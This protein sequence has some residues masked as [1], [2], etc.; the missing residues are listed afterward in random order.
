MEE[1]TPRDLLELR[2]DQEYLRSLIDTIAHEDDMRLSEVADQFRE[3]IQSLVRQRDHWYGRWT[4]TFGV[5][6]LSVLANMALL[7]WAVTR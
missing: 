1:F 4:L 6:L 2:K 7:A 3:D 5:L